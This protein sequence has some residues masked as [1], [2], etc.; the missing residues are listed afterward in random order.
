MYRRIDFEITDN[1]VVV[2]WPQ[3]K[4][5]RAW[6]SEATEIAGI[7]YRGSGPLTIE[8]EL[9]HDLIGSLENTDMILNVQ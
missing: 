3:T 8:P 7:D 5:A 4:R 2:I 9:G 1:S 6:L